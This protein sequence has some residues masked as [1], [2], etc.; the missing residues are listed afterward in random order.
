MTCEPTNSAADRVASLRTKLAGLTTTIKPSEEHTLS[1]GCDALDQLLPGY[2]LRPGMLIEWLSED[3][4]S[5]A[6]SLAFH[7]ARRMVDATQ[8]C[9]VVTDRWR[10][11]YPPAAVARGIETKDLIVVRS[12]DERVMSAA[13]EL[14]ALDQ[15]L[16]C[17]AVGVVMAWLDRVDPR[18]F[19]RLQLAAEAGNTLAL[20]LRPAKVQPLPTWS[21]V[22]LLVKPFCDATASNAST[23]RQ[24][25][26]ENRF[27]TVT[28]LRQRGRVGSNTLEGTSVDLEMDEV[29]TLQAAERRHEESN[30]RQDTRPMHLAPRM[31]HSTTRRRS[32]G[33]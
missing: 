23:R 9:M 32:A 25:V 33:A 20:L 5:G 13:E 28:L 31:A 15:A 14:W 21:D 16:R 1:T 24:P 7:C 30:T 18:A 8:N 6:A 10:R 3:H 27:C 11:F 19:R 2:S 29:G 26:S 12:H 22:Q 4:G 17:P